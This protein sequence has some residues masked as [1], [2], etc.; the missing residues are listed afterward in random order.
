M[1]RWGAKRWKPGGIQERAGRGTDP[2]ETSPNWDGCKNGVIP[3]GAAGRRER[4]GPETNWAGQCGKRTRLGAKPNLHPHRNLHQSE[5]SPPSNRSKNPGKPKE[6]P[7][8]GRKPLVHMGDSARR[9]HPPT[10]CCCPHEVPAPAASL[11][12][13]APLPASS[14][15]PHR[16]RSDM[17]HS[18]HSP[19]HSRGEGKCQGRGRRESGHLHVF[20]TCPKE[21]AEQANMHELSE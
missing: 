6:K 13:R 20:N 8:F 12:G 9:P 3:V 15:T 19:I 1:G 4:K 2:A 16:R 21:D 17:P 7:R 14:H 10:G 5:S 18:P 11:S